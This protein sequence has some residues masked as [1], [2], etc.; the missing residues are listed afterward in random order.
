MQDFS[1]SAKLL[2]MRA[3]LAQV[4]RRPCILVGTSLGGAIAINLAAEVCPE[5]VERVVL[6]DAQ[7]VVL[8]VG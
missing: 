4:V 2:H 3:F 8:F 1:P 5:Q 6:I 7:V